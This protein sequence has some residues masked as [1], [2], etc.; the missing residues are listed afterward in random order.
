MGFRL[1]G[2]VLNL[3]ALGV[4]DGATAAQRYQLLCMAHIARDEPKGDTDRA[5]YYGG[6]EYL[7]RLHGYPA[8]T[9]A[10]EQAVARAMAGLIRAG[11]VKPLGKAGAGRR[12]G[13]RLTLP[14]ALPKGD[15]IYPQPVDE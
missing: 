7:A 6:W 12:Q 1:S 9:P 11:Y 13:Y 2:Q 14:E 8:Y 15:T 5:I 10:A 4:L 3:A